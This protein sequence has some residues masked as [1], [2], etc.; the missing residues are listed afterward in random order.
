MKFPTRT[1]VALAEASDLSR[2]FEKPVQWK[3]GLGHFQRTALV[4]DLDTCMRVVMPHIDK[5]LSLA[6]KQAFQLIHELAKPDVLGLA[7]EALVEALDRK[8]SASK[9]MVAAATV[10]NELY[11][12]KHLIEDVKLTDKLM[13]NLVGK[14]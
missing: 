11:G 6:D 3:D 9:D 13:I 14:E 10:L 4:A 7:M 5:K 2:L 1:A 8:N 12:E